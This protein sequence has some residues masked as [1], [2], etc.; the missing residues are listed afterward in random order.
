MSSYVLSAGGLMAG[1]GLFGG[2][3]PPQ[4]LASVPLVQPAKCFLRS[5]F[6][7]K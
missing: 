2:L 5:Q 6:P 3:P 4:A 1:L 7:L